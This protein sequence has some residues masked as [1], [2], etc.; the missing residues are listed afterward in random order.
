MLSSKVTLD[1]CDSVK[2][3]IL[4]Y[5]DQISRGEA[6]AN[7]YIYGAMVRFTNDLLRDDIYFDWAEAAEIDAFYKSLTLVGE[8]SDKPFVLLPWQLF[9]VCNI[10]CWKR[11]DG[12]MKHR[13]S[14]IC[15]AKGAGKTTMLAA[16]AL[17]DVTRKKGQR[18]YAIANTEVQAS[19]LLDTARSMA[20]NCP[21]LGL[22]VTQDSIERRAEDCT[23]TT[24]PA[25]ERSLQGLAPSMFIADEAS[26][27]RGR[28]LAALLTAGV[29][30]SEVCGVVISTPSGTVDNHFTELVTN[31]RSV[32]DGSLVDDT[33]FQMLFGI[34]DEDDLGDEDCW[35]KAN[36]SMPYGQP[37]LQSL[38]RAWNTMKSSGMGRAEFSIYHAARASDTGAGLLDM[39]LW[40]SMCEPD[41]DESVLLG[42]PC[43]IGMDLSKSGD[44]SVCSLL[45]PLDDGRIYIKGRYWFPSENLQ[46]RELDYRLPCRKFHAEGWL[47]LSSG[48]HI[49]YELIRVALGEYHKLYNIKAVAYD[50]WG[51]TLLCNQLLSDGLPMVMYRQAISTLGP[52]TGLFVNTWLAKK[53]VFK[54]DPILKSA[55]SIVEGKKDL[56][57][58]VRPC[59]SRSRS[60]I[61]PVIACIMANHT[62]G[63]IAQSIYESELNT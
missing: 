24:L 61:D 14:L 31:A 46:Q 25:L 21:S 53:F 39:S 56:N 4:Q 50:N 49:D 27:Y 34:G 44:M 5:V 62:L 48:A 1:N 11:L 42:R 36:P 15:V 54:Q 13:F 51:A 30:R 38:R 17:Y 60:I 18:T 63:G 45:F 2:E 16:L 41:F 9:T 55:C 23:F 19:L 26:S 7:K 28:F 3:T 12:K 59:K 37:E 52:G 58:N 22:L 47:D 33:A 8:F 29:K 57:G 32:L 20:A 6:P 43:W 35:I 40:D 10:R